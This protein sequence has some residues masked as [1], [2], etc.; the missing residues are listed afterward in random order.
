MEWFTVTLNKPSADIIIKSE[1]NS[2]IIIEN[3]NIG[4]TLHYTTNERRVINRALNFVKAPSNEACENIS[5]QS[6][7][8]VDEAKCPLDS[9][10]N[11]QLNTRMHSAHL[12]TLRAVYIINSDNLSLSQTFTQYTVQQ[13]DQSICSNN[14]T[15]D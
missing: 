10:L 2:F 3:R 6:V 13:R 8:I 12:L 9:L 1:E 4:P 14:V 15:I 5:D 11:G 7:V